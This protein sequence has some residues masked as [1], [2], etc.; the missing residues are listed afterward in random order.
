MYLT[1]ARA[2]RGLDF[3]SRSG[4][5]QKGQGGDKEE[6]DRVSQVTNDHDEQC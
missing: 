3:C 5:G 4:F 1:Q 2:L 6:R